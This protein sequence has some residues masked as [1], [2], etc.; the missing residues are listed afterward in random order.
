M[1]REE[2]KPSLREASCCR[3]EVRNGG[4]GVALGRLAFDLIDGE[5]GTLDRLFDGPGR[6]LVLE[7]ELAELLPG[8]RIAARP[9][10]RW[11]AG[12]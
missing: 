5:A 7:I 8:D 6:G 1:V 4:V 12:W 10:I 9:R 3:V 2:E 11:P